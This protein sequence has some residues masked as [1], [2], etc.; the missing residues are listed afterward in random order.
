MLPKHAWILT[1]CQGKD[2]WPVTFKNTT[3]PANKYVRVDSIET[4]D[5]KSYEDKIKKLEAENRKLKK[6]IKELEALKYEVN[7]YERPDE[8]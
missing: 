8:E 7:V 6:Q 1:N 5:T 2:A 3:L 4:V